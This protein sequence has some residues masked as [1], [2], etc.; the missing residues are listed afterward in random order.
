MFAR[1]AAPGFLRALAAALGAWLWL[2]QPA[3]AQSPVDALAE[4]WAHSPHARVE[5]EAFVHWDE[6]GEVPVD[7]ATCHSGPGFRDFI[8]AD[9]SAAGVVDNP[10]P[11]RSVIDCATCHGVVA[12]ALASVVFPSG[13][14]VA[15]LGSSARCM[16]CHQGREST[17]SVNARIGDLDDDAVS[18]DLAFV[19]VHYRAAAASLLGSMVKGAYEYEGKEYVGRFAHPPPAD[20]CTGCH[21]PHA[22]EVVVETCAACHQNQALPAIRINPADSDSDGDTSEGVAGEIATMHEAL[23][24]AIGAHAADSAGA[25]VAYSPDAYPYFFND[26]NANG[27]ADPDETVFP[28]RYQSWT[29]RLLRAA[30]N[31][32]FVA[33]DPGIY[34]HNPRYA[35]QILY[36]SI[37]DLGTAV[38]VDVDGMVR[39]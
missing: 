14:T 21:D 35:M 17:V 28:N 19:N 32:Q 9:G 7:C 38:P 25:P 36:D 12:G 29:P 5:A 24:A 27:V 34:A 16:V 26:G 30:Y 13:A 6:E 22:L 4:A 2:A 10:A 8:G 20:T 15:D 23:L 18:A 33:K 11:I 39:P 37:A 31:Y 3:P 1:L